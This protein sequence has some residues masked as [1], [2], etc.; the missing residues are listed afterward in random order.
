[1]RVHLLQYCLHCINELKRFFLKKNFKNRKL[2]FYKIKII[3]CQYDA[4]L[5]AIKYNFNDVEY[6]VF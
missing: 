4:T 3:S 2:N 5:I 6:R 1:M